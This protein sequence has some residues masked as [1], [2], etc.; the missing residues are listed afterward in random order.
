MLSASDN[1]LLTR[2]GPGTPMGA[3]FRR[4]WHPVLLADELSESDGPP[5]RVRVLGEDL[6]A[7]RDTKGRV[8]FIAAFC[9]HRR[10]SLFFGRNEQCG[11]RCVYHGWKFDLDG[12]CVDMPSE[13]AT[14]TYKDKVSI[15]AYPAA[16][17]GGCIWIYMGP[18][19]KEPALPHFEWARVPESQRALSRWLQESNYMQAVEGEIDSAHVSWLHSPLR[20][21]DSPFRGRFDDAILTDGAPDL[22]IKPTEYGFCYGARRNAANARYYWRVTQWLLPTFS[23]IPSRVFPRGGR[24]WI[25]IDDSHISVIQ[26]SYHPDRP[27]TDEEVKRTTQSPNV[28]PVRYRLPDGVTI[29]ICRDVRRAEN[30]YLID[31]KMQRTENF[32][33]IE[34]IRSQDTAM[35]ESMGGIVDRTGEHLGTTDAAVIAAR[36]RLIQMARDLADGIEPSEALRPEIYNVRA[37]DLVSPEDDFFNLMDL[38][39]EEAVGRLA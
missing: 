31:R 12:N 5:V 26:Y 36:R 22:T 13:P 4:F 8:G 9:P 17:Y 27:L 23:L 19:D 37:L 15:K 11:V 16:E 32:T 3:L 33:G 30:D 24:C 1:E 20:A 6:I 25:P 7:V 21:S 28:E 34:V 10:A 38:H 2:T 35:T 18:P 29:D 14:S 39:A